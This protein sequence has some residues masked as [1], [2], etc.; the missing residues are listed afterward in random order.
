MTKGL[1]NRW[2]ER[3]SNERRKIQPKTFSDHVFNHLKNCG[4]DSVSREDELQWVVIHVFFIDM[5]FSAFIELYRM[6]RHKIGLVIGMMQLCKQ[7]L[8]LWISTTWSI[9][10]GR[11]FASLPGFALCPSELHSNTPSQGR[12]LEVC[13]HLHVGRGAGLRLREF[14]Q[15]NV[16]Q[17][18]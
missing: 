7:I 3:W 17:R 4:L 12:L 18:G 9:C 2:K 15:F 6:N 5:S 11:N 10:C 14:H 13:D 16:D 8:V 1:K